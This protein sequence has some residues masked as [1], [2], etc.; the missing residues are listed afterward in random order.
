MK[1]YLILY[2]IIIL[3]VG[4]VSPKN[5]ETETTNNREYSVFIDKSTCVEYLYNNYLKK[6]GI[7]VRYNRD[8]TIKI[9]E[10]CLKENNNGK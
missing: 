7:T 9:N 5:Y 6:G 10:D 8:G 4:C 2:L 1:K 3:C